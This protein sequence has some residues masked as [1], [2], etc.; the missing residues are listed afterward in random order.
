MRSETCR[1]T[2]VTW[3]ATFVGLVR[4]TQPGLASYLTWMTLL[5]M[6]CRRVMGETTI[7]YRRPCG[8]EFESNHTLV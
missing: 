3:P 5:M 8:G 4:Q 6:E 7:T 2:P 1:Q